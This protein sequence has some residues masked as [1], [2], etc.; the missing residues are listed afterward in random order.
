MKTCLFVI[1]GLLSVGLLSLNAETA[2]DIAQRFEQQKLA[3]LETYLSE[4]PEAEDKDLALTLIIGAK[5]SSGDFE[6]VPSL[7]SQRYELQPKGPDADLNAII[8]EIVQP[9][10]QTAVI[11]GDRD[12]AKALI[13]QVKSDFSASPQSS[14]LN[15]ILDQIGADLYLPGVGDKMEIAFTSTTGD[16]IDVAAMKDKVILIDFWATWCGPCIAEMPNVVAAYDKY[17]EEGFEVIGISLDDD[18]A[19]LNQFIADNEMPWPQYFDGKG[20]E[21]EIAQRFGIGSI[22]ATFLVGKD[23]TIVASNLRGPALEEAVEKALAD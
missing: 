18:E 13:T 5:L 7:L 1:T 2:A 15:Q 19:K 23:G 17:H 22:P 16:D 10:V 14:Q 3:A 4:N 12:A 6:S 11:T 21:N 8:Q 9:M 20:W